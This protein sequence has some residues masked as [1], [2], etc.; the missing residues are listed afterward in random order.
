MPP[1]VYS[2]QVEL[3]VGNTNH[4]QKAFWLVQNTAHASCILCIE[5]VRI[6]M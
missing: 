4:L 5:A 1:F 6:V 2:V 3:N